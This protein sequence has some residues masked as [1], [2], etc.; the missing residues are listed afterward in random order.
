MPCGLHIIGTERH[1][2]G[3]S[4]GSCADAPAARATRA[5][6][7]FFLSLEDD[8]MRLFG[9]ERIAG[10]M[11]RLGVQ[12]GEVIAH[13]LVTK[14]IERAQKRVEAQ[15]FGIRKRLL[16]YDDVMNQQ[17]EVIYGLRNSVLDGDDVR[18]RIMEMLSAAIAS[19]VATYLPEDSKAG[20][21]DL[22]GLQ[23][24]MEALSSLPGQFRRGWARRP[25]GT[26]CRR[27]ALDAAQEAYAN[28]EAIFGEQ[29]RESSAAF[30]SR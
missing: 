15:N 22:S 17:R 6:S 20:D 8:L 10:I 26:K 5:S 25:G 14:S 24:E 30:C 2:A 1:E 7:R 23:G 29:M 21:W 9:S 19:R 16:E 18:D 28:R 3:A 13:S 11:E 4:T 27:T 12:E